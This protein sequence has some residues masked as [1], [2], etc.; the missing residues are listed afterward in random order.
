MLGLSGTF[1]FAFA[2]L[3]HGNII[4]DTLEQSHFQKYTTLEVRGPSGPQLLVGG[5]LGQ[6]DFVLRALRALRPCD[7]RNDV[8]IVRVRWGKKS[9]G[10]TRRF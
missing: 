8:V 3:T 2:H 4:F 9:D 10:R 5:P 6:L 7:P 1:Y